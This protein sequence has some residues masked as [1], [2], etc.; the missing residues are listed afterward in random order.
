[1][2]AADPRVPPLLADEPDHVDLAGLTIGYFD[3]DPFLEPVPAIARAVAEAR[4]ALQAAG[5]A[6]VPHR[7]VASEDILFLWLGAISAD[8]GRTIERALAGEPPSPQLKPSRLI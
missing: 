3:D 4:D 2:S 1:Q 6:L 8:G 5:A 7:P